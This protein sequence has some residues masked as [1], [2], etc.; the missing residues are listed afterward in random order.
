MVSEMAQK[1][2]VEMAQTME[3]RSDQLMEPPKA[4]D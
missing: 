1:M 2:A 4:L 3:W